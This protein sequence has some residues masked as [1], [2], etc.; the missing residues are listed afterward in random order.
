M[1]RIFEVFLPR[2]E[3]TPSELSD[4]LETL[5]KGDECV[6]FVDDEQV[7]ADIGRQ[8]L[9]HLGYKCVPK[10]NPMEALRAFGADP[11]KFDLVITDQTMPSM[12]GDRLAKEL[13]RIRPDVPII[14]CTGYS[15]LITEDDARE[16]GIREFV[17]KPLT[18]SD[19][20]RTVRKVLDKD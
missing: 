17:M 10:T 6:L 13:L 7:L 2:V 19:L 20:A 1:D 15:E 18:L 16:R 12:T 11:D 8:M 3:T 4:A 5:Y 9:E 14:L